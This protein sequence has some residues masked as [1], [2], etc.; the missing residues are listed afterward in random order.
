[1]RYVLLA[2]LVIGQAAFAK[3]HFLTIG[4]GSSAFNNQIS[5]EKN[6]LF[7]Q[8]ILA[9]VAPGAAHE[10][11]F[12]DGV[13]AGRDVQFDDPAYKPPR[14][15]VMLSRIFSQRTGELYLQFR[16]N[17]IRNVR[18]SSARASISQWFNDIG[19]K[20]DDEDRLFIYFTGHG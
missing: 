3:D 9:D 5:L 14:L 2:V 17:Q 8:R 6:V 1:M 18:G 13:D 7:L 19:A 4:G 12:A 11:L 20:L 10:I 15:N 16:S